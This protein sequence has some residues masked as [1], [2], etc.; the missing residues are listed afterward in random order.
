MSGGGKN[1][2]SRK[3]VNRT[4][5]KSDLPPPKKQTQKQTNKTYYGFSNPKTN[6]KNKTKNKEVTCKEFLL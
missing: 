2:N 6:K 3:I 5:I 1:K 4:K